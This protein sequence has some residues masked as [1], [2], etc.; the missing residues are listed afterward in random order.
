MDRGEAVVARVQQELLGHR[1]RKN[2][3]LYKIRNALRPGNDKLTARQITR[4]EAG[5]QAGDPHFEVTVAW[6]F[7]QHIRSAYHAQ[8]LAEGRVIAV[9]IVGSF[10]TCP[11]LHSSQQRPL[12]SR[13]PSP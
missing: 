9:K 2:D 12:G 8:N 4:I 3:P 11:I 10:H 6:R 5:L 7:Y 13:A 1:G